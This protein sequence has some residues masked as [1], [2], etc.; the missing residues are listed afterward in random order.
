[1]PDDGSFFAILA[2]SA[3]CQELGGAPDDERD[4]DD[5]AAAQDDEP[6]GRYREVLQDGHERLSRLADRVAESE[7]LGWNSD[8]RFF[9]QGHGNG[10]V[11]GL[12]QK[13][14]GPALE[15]FDR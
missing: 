12:V 6:D 8:G 1:M 10:G 11:R 13:V 2:T 3:F 14:L 4:W 5:D 15:G 9:G 7:V